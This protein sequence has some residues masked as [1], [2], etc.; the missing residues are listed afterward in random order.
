MD[1]ENKEESKPVLRSE[2]LKRSYQLGP[3]TLNILQGVDLEVMAGERLAIMGASG[4]GK[5]TL[6]NLLG[7]LDEPDSGEVWIDGQKV[8]GMTESQ[9]ASLRNKSLGFVFQFH[10]LL[11]EFS[12]LEN[13]A[14]PL[15][16]R[17]DS[18][19]KSAKIAKEVLAR[20][21][22][23]GRAHHKPAE[24]SG[25]ERQRVAIARALAGEP[26]VLLMDEPT[27]N[28][29]KANAIK[30]LDLI[31]HLNQQTGSA[32]IVVTHDP[33]IASHMD[34]SL[35]LVEGQLRTLG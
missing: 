2:G 6:L 7:A 9:R 21:G 30:V 17:G 4:A 15:W 29:D 22:L 14:M 11:S 31:E 12:A 35:E 20:V 10:H 25:G 32:L 1:A 13:V 23:E 18:R 24:L 33:E 16:L 5:T 28:L 26:K 3:E 8:K 34:R 19:A 27:G